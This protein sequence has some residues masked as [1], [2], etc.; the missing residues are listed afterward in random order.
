MAAQHHCFIDAATQ[1]ENLG[2][3]VI[4]R[5]LLRL[6]EARSTVHVDVRKVPDWAVETI[7]VDP[8][9]ADRRRGFTLRA[10]AIG[11]RGRLR[12]TSDTATI[13]LKPG[14]IGGRYEFSRTIARLGLLGLT[15]LCKVLGVPVIRLGFSV[16]DLKSPL[17]EIE[18]AQSW[19]QAIY[20]PRDVVSESYAQSAGLRT[21]G[22]STDLAYTLGVVDDRSI[23]RSGVTL[24]F[25]GSTDGHP[26]PSYASRLAP[27]LSSYVELLHESDTPVRWCAQVVRDS[28]YGDRV[29][30]GDRRVGRVAFERSGASADRVFATYRASD[31]VLTNRLHSFLFA[32]SQG[33]L[34]VVVTDP[35]KHGKICGIVEEMGL[36]E[37][38]IPL[39]GLTAAGL[40]QRV[41]QLRQDR[42]RIL[43]VVKAY[44]DDQA[45]RLDRLMD[46]WLGSEPQSDSYPSGLRSAQAA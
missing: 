6:L 35:D 32:L 1:I 24:S 22:R 44:F 14:H 23:A 46:G 40:Q 31:L 37:L 30:G 2:D 18:R 45:L 29:V 27:L 7:K 3:D 39:G 9:T 42:E 33:A 28:S 17:L 19:M 15:A 10:L 5:Q 11:L 41:Q 38:L 21:T 16:D 20:A 36:P 43:S 13:V 12:L 34:A 4:L 26:Q 8:R 25:A